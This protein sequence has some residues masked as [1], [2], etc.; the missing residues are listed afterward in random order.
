MR[1]F[2]GSWLL[3]VALTLSACGLQAEAP[4]SPLR[5]PSEGSGSTTV[6]DIDRTLETRVEITELSSARRPTATIA[7]RTSGWWWGFN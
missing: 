2:S 4:E 6:N 1:R 7:C 3:M 5:E